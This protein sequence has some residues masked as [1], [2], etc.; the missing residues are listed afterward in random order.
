MKEAVSVPVGAETVP[1]ITLL[2]ANNPTS[3]CKRVL[4]P[5]EAQ[6]DV[7]LLAFNAAIEVKTC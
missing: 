6:I 7:F 2:T 3:K 1:T 5:T 4:L